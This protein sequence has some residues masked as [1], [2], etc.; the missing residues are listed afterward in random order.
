MSLSDRL[1]GRRAAAK[2]QDDDERDD[3]ESKRAQG[4]DDDDDKKE[5]KRAQGDDDDDEDSAKSKRSKKAKAQ[6]DDDE[7]DEGMADDDDKEKAAAPGRVAQLCADAGVPGLARHLIDARLGPRGVRRRIDQAV[8]IKA[9]GARLRGR[10]PAVSAAIAE[11]IA[12]KGMSVQAAK[13]TFLDLIAANQS[14]DIRGHHQPGGPA[15]AGQSAD[16]HGWGNAIAKAT[17]AKNF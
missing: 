7:D 6:D 11:E 2:A 4:E 14:G 9:L 17:G 5:S 13:A 8:E 10:W 3:E 1:R 15:P 16:V 12:V